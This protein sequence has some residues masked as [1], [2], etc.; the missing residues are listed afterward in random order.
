MGVPAS[1]QMRLCLPFEKYISLMVY[2]SWLSVRLLLNFILIS[3]YLSFWFYLFLGLLGDL[4]L[5]FLEM[6]LLMVVSSTLFLLLLVILSSSSAF[7]D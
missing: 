6:M 5:L 2:L 7:L 3:T 4:L 1:M